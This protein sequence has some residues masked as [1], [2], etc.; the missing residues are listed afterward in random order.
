MTV[1]AQA[2]SG[3][4]T[5]ARPHGCPWCRGSHGH[6]G[7][8]GPYPTPSPSRVAHACAPAQVPL[9]P[10]LT[11]TLPAA[12]GVT[13]TAAQLDHRVPC[14]GYVLREHDPPLRP[15][16]ERLAEHGLTAVRPR[17]KASQV[18]SRGTRSLAIPFSGCVKG[19]RAMG[20]SELLEYRQA[21][22]GLLAAWA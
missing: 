11:W 18:L 10:G 21:V 2:L 17:F 22:L 16:H 7:R 1:I 3:L 20:F 4:L 14:W 8:V 13:I 9:V 6:E 15:Q 12:L 19:E 5:R